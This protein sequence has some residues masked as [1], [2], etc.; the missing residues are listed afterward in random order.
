[1]FERFTEGA[2]RA[3]FFARYEASELGSTGIDT[4]H[5]LLGLIR[6]GKGLTTRVF[7]DAGI[8]LDDMRNEVLRRAPE[9]PKIATSVEIPFS[10]AAKHALQH[11]AQ[12]ADRLSH[13]Y[14]GTEHLLLGLLR[15]Q[16]SVATDVLT[17]RGL[18]FDQVRKRIVELLSYGQRLGHPGPPPTPANTFKWPWLRFVPSRAVHILYSELK[19]PQQPITNGSGPGLQ[20]YGYTLTEAIVSAWHGNRWHVDIA[21]G[22]DDGTRYDFYIQL[23][24]TEPW[25]TFEQMWRDGIEQQFDLSVTRE[26]R[27]RDVWVA[28]GVGHGGPMLRSYGEAKAGIGFVT[29]NLSLAMKRP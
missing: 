19:P 11:A 5:L 21:D 22:L 10:A 27:P 4:E 7:A 23:A 17:S 25:E 24:Q 26:T 13:D 12:E 6:E 28:R 1:M 29:A 15:E 16:G 18:H 2:R 14:I 3:L 8:T 20:A 9:Q